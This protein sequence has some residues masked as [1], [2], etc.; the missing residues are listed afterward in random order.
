MSKIIDQ[1]TIDLVKNLE[2]LGLTEKE[3]LV[4]LALLPRRD[5]GSSKLIYAT[6]L[7]KQFIYNALGKLEELGLAKHVIQN[8]RKKFS[9]TSPQRIVTIIEEKK[10]SAQNIAKELQ[11]RYAGAHEQ[12]AE[13]FQGDTAFT[14]RQMQIL[15]HV[16]DGG[17]ICVIASASEKFGYT[18]REQGLW[19][20]WERMRAEKNIWIRYLGS[21]SQLETLQQREKSEKLFDYRILPGQA[22][23]LMN[24]DIWH[25]VVS[26]NIFGDPTLCIT[27]T[28]KEVTDGYRQFFETLWNL[29]KKK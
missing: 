21:E 12:D 22:T 16:P 9:A 4:Y 3:A 24:T 28:G 29:G 6:G 2:T 5:T 13:V 27:I 20:E 18:F 19:E 26:L 15:E 25:D 7:H 14:M 23:G 8:G 11:K 17:F 10:L 1:N